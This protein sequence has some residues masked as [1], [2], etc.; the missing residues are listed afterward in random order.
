[1]STNLNKK[2]RDNFFMS[3]ALKQAMINL[4]N[5]K[6]NPSVG[7]IITKNNYIISSGHTGINGRPHAE[8][9]AIKRCRE[10]LNN[11][12]LYVTLEPCSHYGKTAPCVKEIIKNKF[13][14]V[15]FS[16]KDPDERSF[17][18][19]TNILKRK[20]INVNIGILSSDIKKFY[21]SYI[22]SKK[23]SLPFVTCKLAVSKDFFTINKRKKWITNKY[24]RARVHLM[25]SQHDAIITS[26]RTIKIDNPFL[27]CRINGLKMTSPTIFVLDNHL[28]ISLRSNVIKNSSKNN[29]IVLYNK[30]NRKKIKFLKK[31]GVR[32]YKIE[33]NKNGDLNLKDVL[34][35]VKELGYYRI[36]LESGIRMASNFIK[37]NLVND[38]KIYISS[39]K[40]NN[41][42]EGN[43]N[44][45]FKSIL[46][47]KK[48]TIEKVNLFGDK[49]ISYKIK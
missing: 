41:N 23:N 24:S 6:E 43:L 45:N 34:I 17:N 5:T 33:L 2:N 29:I 19:S 4:G 15:F 10:S 12:N 30:F 18:K 26:S 28:K 11:S 3:L 21:E 13:N 37:G 1:M 27:N 49:L 16:I 9:N 22:L 46:K 31:L 36:F 42:G 8:Y 35:K 44:N 39:K 25:R 38:L 32:T 48:C 20:K 7:C 14:K 47:R 40:L